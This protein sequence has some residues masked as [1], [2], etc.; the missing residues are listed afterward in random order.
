MTPNRIASAAGAAVF[1]VAGVWG[2]VVSLDPSVDPVVGPLV[3]GQLGTSV[4]LSLAHLAMA[5]AL[6]AGA[7]RGERLARPTNVG[8]GTVLFLLGLFGLFAVGTPVNVIGLNGAA[9]L[10]HFAASSALLA[11]GLGAAKTDATRRRD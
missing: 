2:L 8:A 11:T 4:A 7:V 9:N 6:T 5:V 1:A 10:L 3:A